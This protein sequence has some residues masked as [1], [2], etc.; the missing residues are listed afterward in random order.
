MPHLKKG[1]G[2]W[3]S[4]FFYGFKPLYYWFRQLEIS[5]HLKNILG[6]QRRFKEI[7]PGLKE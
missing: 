7:L 6:G 2:P 1:V 5:R 4:R 3:L